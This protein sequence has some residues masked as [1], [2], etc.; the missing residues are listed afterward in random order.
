MSFILEI[1]V[2]AIFDYLIGIPGAVILWLFKKREGSILSVE[3]ENR[4]TSIFIGLCFW[5]VFAMILR[6]LASS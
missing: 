1:L 6:F 3:A 4:Y 5:I 2:L